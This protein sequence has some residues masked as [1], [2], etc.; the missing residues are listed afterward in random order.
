M[1]I[2][3]AAVGQLTDSLLSLFWPGVTPLGLILV[4]WDRAADHA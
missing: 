4:V 3:Q 1:S 2:A